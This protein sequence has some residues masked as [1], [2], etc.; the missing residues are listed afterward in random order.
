MAVRVDL[1]SLSHDL[2]SNFAD[3]SL[4]T[5]H[6]TAQMRLRSLM[7]QVTLFFGIAL[8]ERCLD[9]HEFKFFGAIGVG[10]FGSR[11]IDMAASQLATLLE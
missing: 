2:M 3:I 6:L 7:F 4:H 1:A 8:E 10:H 5:L 11:R 9:G